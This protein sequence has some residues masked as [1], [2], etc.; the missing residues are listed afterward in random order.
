MAIQKSRTQCVRLCHHVTRWIGLSTDCQCIYYVY[1]Y[2]VNVN[3]YQLDSLP[4][5]YKRLTRSR[6]GA[7]R[8]E[9][10]RMMRAVRSWSNDRQLAVS[11][12]RTAM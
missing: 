8:P 4:V 10:T 6:R 11:G 5:N 3:C 9:L 1:V 12:G 7:L 2:T